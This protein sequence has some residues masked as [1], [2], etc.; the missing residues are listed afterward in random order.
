MRILLVEDDAHLGEIIVRG[1]REEGYQVDCAAGGNEAELFLRTRTY[2][3]IVL[4]RMLPDIRGEEL[5]K[6][7]R[8]RDCNTP[9]LILT[10]LDAVSDRVTGLKAGADDYLG[11]PFAFAEL[12]ARLEALQRRTSL[13][14]SSVIKAGNL[15]L[16]PQTRLLTSQKRSV[17]LNRLEYELMD[18]FLRHPGQ[19]LGKETLAEQCWKEPWDASDN[20]IEAQIKNLRKKLKLIDDREWIKTM[21]GVGYRLEVV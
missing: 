12:L 18:I 11:K 13:N 4:D 19:V 6:K 5:L 10:A 9:V 14:T 2:G 7:W 1:L 21:R 3:V 15:E 16:N 8:Q 20:T 17:L